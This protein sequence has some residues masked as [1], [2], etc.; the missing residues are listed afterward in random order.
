MSEHSSNKIDFEHWSTLASTDPEQFEALRQDRIST[1]I[2]QTSGQR[3]QRL[4]GL[5]WQIDRVRSQHK[6][7]T[8][9]A[10]LA[11]SELMWKTFSELADVLQAQAESNLSA[12]LPHMDANIIAFPKKAEIER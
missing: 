6:N 3:Q 12:A 5:Q 10:C 11:I 9:A 8:V 1:L 7:S 2:N 4:L